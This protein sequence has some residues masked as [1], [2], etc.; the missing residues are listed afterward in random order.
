MRNNH[1][2]ATNEKGFMDSYTFVS[3]DVLFTTY[4]CVNRH[5]FKN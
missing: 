1:F 2:S 3:H 5:Y 4:E